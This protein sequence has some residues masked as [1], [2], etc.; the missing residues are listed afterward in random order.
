MARTARQDVIL[1]EVPK[2]MATTI[3]YQT[4][5]ILALFVLSIGLVA[6]VEAIAGRP[7]GALIS[8]MTS[9]PG[10]TTTTVLFVAALGLDVLMGRAFRSLLILA[11]AAILL[12]FISR[13]KQLYLSDPLYPSDLLFARQIKELLPVMISAQ[14]WLAIGVG[15]A[16][17]ATVALVFYCAFFAWR[18]FPVLSSRARLFRLVFALPFLVGFTPMMKYTDHSWLRDRLAIVPMMWDQAANYSHN[19]FLIAFAFNLPM[20]HVSPPA[21]YNG[22]TIADI[23][24]DPAAF[25]VARKRSPDVIVIMSES[26]WDPTR[27]PDVRFGTDPMPV[28]RKNQAG[29]IFSPEFGGM[30]ANVEFE[31]LTGFSNAFLPYG[32]IPYQQYVR[33]PL[34]SLATFF[35]HKGY[36]SVALH[37]FEGWFW[38]RSNVYQHLGFDSFLSQ[39]NLPALEKRGMFASDTALTNEIIRVAEE[40]DKPLFMFAVTLQGH[41]P[42]EADRYAHN[43]VSVDSSLT[44]GAEQQIATYSEGVKEADDSLA[45]LMEWA[46]DRPRETII[47]LFGDHLPPM[48]SVFL[49]TGYMTNAV[50]TRRASL[51]TMLREHETP[52]V[53]WS[54]KT[55]PKKDFGTISPALLSHHIVQSAGFSDPFYTGF[56][57]KVAEQYSVIDRYMLVGADQTSQPG[58]NDGGNKADPVLKNYRLLQ[59]DMMFGKQYAKDRFFPAPTDTFSAPETPVADMSQSPTLPG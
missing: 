8:F 2:G 17:L 9:L 3:G 32:S 12:A 54:S 55:G 26:L 11:P 49:E 15:L 50:A 24:V 22:G 38:N 37:P 1:A 13:Q 30:T 21:G 33:G 41:G 39:E 42:Y 34:P 58:W 28:I 53:I 20:S 25:T 18:R 46:R 16:S 6:A 44:P 43:R 59:Y 7:A 4:A 19:G 40:S 57:G 5:L 56:L 48:G 35:R 10:I 45:K 29:N 14:P 36:S 52:L 47:V 51:E 27:L 31:A 23:P